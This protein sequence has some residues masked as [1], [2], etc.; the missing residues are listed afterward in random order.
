MEKFLEIVPVI[1]ATFFMVASLISYG[2]ANENVKKNYSW[3]GWMLTGIL[4]MLMLLTSAVLVL[5][6]EIGGR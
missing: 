1:V 5:V 4:V 2:K 3:V 6:F